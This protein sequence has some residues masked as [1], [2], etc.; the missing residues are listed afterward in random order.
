MWM[1]FPTELL[2]QQRAALLA[3]RL[4]EGRAMT[5]TEAA[6]ALGLSD[7]GALYL[8]EKLSEV[9]PLYRDHG[10]WHWLEEERRG[11]ASDY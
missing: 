3:I 9:L 1:D 10:C 2:S 4:R 11:I 8:L 7:R 6:D 5:T